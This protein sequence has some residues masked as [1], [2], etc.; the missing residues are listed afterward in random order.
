MD[1]FI[2]EVLQSTVLMIWYSKWFILLGI[3]L[4]V[5]VSIFV[6]KETVTRGL[7]RAGLIGIFVAIGLG[8][9][10]PL[11][12]CS[13]IPLIAGLL[14]AGV[15]WSTVMPFMI[16]SPMTS[17]LVFGLLSGYLGSRFAFFQMIAVALLGA[18]TG[19]IVLW[20]ERSFLTNQTRPFV[21]KS[22][23]SE[24]GKSEKNP[25]SSEAKEQTSCG[26]D[27]AGRVKS[28]APF[29]QPGHRSEESCGCGVES[30]RKSL[31]QNLKRRLAGISAFFP[32]IWGLF[33]ERGWLVLKTLFFMGLIGGTIAKLVPTSL[34]LNWFGSGNALSVPIAALAGLP[35]QVNDMQV[36]PLMADLSHKGLSGGAA[37]A[38]LMTGPGACI[39]SLSAVWAMARPRLFVFYLLLVLLGSISAGWAYNLI[40]GSSF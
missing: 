25:A 6:Q 28:Q 4:S 15:P 21:L 19:L 11:C 37:L 7:R 26:C 27:G 8:V 2:L 36:L 20:G 31:P 30:G 13:Q 18:V 9:L 35:L 24:F 3:F 10:S 34:I 23:K 39:Q 38:F 33:R 29:L 1:Q 22:K 12:S 40:M 14:A 17:P 5:V 16:S 32:E